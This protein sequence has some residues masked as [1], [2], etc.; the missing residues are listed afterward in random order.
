MSKTKDWIASSYNCQELEFID[1]ETQDD[2][3]SG[4]YNNPEDEVCT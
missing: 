3:K 2:E 1:A 4:F